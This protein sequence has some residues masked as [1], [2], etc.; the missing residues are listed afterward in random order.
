[1]EFYATVSLSA[2]ASAS[3]TPFDS[4]V[5]FLT[6]AANDKR[7]SPQTSAFDVV[8]MNLRRCFAIV[9]YSILNVV[10]PAVF[11]NEPTTYDSTSDT[12]TSSN[13]ATDGDPPSI[14]KSGDASSV[15]GNA[16]SGIACKPM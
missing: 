11:T 5:T 7:T 8:V 13:G 4:R 14:Y 1:M 15:T 12:F 16:F 10:S 9:S 2:D 6:F 3:P